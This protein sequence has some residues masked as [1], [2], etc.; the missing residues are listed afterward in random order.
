M[1]PSAPVYIVTKGRWKSRRT[2]RSLELIGVPYLIV[3]EDQELSEYA[4][5]I[6]KKK[7]LVLDRQYQR[8][9][10]TCDDLGDTKSLGPGPARNFVW[11]H[12][13]ANGHGWHWVMDDNIGTE[14]PTGGFYRF[15]K[16]L[17]V[18]VSDGTIFKCM[19]DFVSRYSNVSMAG[20]NYFMVAR[21]KCKAP[22]FILNTRIYSCNLIKNA[23]RF[24]WRGRYNEDTDLSLRMLKA[25][26]CTILFNAFLQEK[27]PTLTMRGG[28]TDDIYKGGTLAKSQMLVRLHPDV[29]K[30]AWRW[31]RP[32]HYVD[33]SGFKK[34]GLIRRP[35]LQ[36]PSEIDNYGMQLVAV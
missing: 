9:Y 11:D 29:A 16:N 36:V 27:M 19:E 8:D 31:G 5:V 10:E 32:H 7:I 34:N 25:G 14:C 17:K 3:V 2:S 6:D 28:N 12:S 18:Q 35:G 1:K 30:L 13:S 26:L 23:A 21:R 22:P 15:N 4:S 20:P 33:Y 24:R